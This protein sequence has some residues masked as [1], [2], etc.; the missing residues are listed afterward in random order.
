MLF[1]IGANLTHSD[2]SLDLVEVLA[3]AQAAG[4][5]QMSVTG[6]SIEGSHSALALSRQHD[7]C[8]YFF[9]RSYH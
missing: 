8:P 7:S 2:F 4:V 9:F 5:S 6:A 3:R 1:D